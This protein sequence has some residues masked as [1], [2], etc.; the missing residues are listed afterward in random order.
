MNHFSFHPYINKDIVVSQ[1]Q[2]YIKYLAT[3]GSAKIYENQEGLL[4]QL[5]KDYTCA[6]LHHAKSEDPLLSHAYPMQKWYCYP[7]SENLQRIFYSKGMKLETTYKGLI[8]N[9]ASHIP[10]IQPKGDVQLVFVE[11]DFQ[12]DLWCEV[13]NQVWS[14]ISYETASDLFRKFASY[15]ENRIKL[16]LAIEGSMPVGCSVLDLT[17]SVAGMYEDAVIPSHRNRLIGSAML[18][19][20]LRYAWEKGAENA[21]VIVPQNSESYAERSGFHSCCDIQC[22]L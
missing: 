3:T 13:F 14:N 11:S 17:G 7:P 18:S 21:V 1:F 8:R 12:F 9:L 5:G 16:V 20:R 10:R 4:A 2:G 22:Y 6:V 19:K 15:K